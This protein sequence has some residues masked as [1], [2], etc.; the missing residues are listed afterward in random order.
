M[1]LFV[2]LFTA[3]NVMALSFAYYGPGVF[4]QAAVPTGIWGSVAELFEYLLLFLTSVVVATLGLPMFLDALHDGAGRLGWINARTL[5]CAGVFAAFV[6]SAWHTL[7]GIDPIYYDTVTMV[8]V[9]VTIGKNLEARAKRR[10]SVEL[11]A[12]LTELPDRIDVVRD[13]RQF[14]IETAALRIGDV[15]CVR[16]GQVVPVDGVIEGGCS[17]VDASG[18]TGEPHAA[19]LS[20]GDRVFAGSI[21]IDGM[22][23]V[24]AEHVASERL[25]AHVDRLLREAL[26]HRFPA[27][28][29]ADTVA[30]VLA[31]AVV[32][33][34]LAVT[35]A[36]ARRGAADDG[37][38][39]GL[40]VLLI[41]CPCALA[42]GPGL[43]MAAAIR[44]AARRGIVF[45]SPTMVEQVSRLKRMY[46][47]KTGTL[48]GATSTIEAVFVADTAHPDETIELLASIGA[49]GDHPIAGGMV[50]YA[51]ERGVR[52]R[53]VDA[54]RVLPGRGVEA[55]VDGRRFLLGGARLLESI[56]LDPPFDRGG[57]RVYLLADG[58][59]LASAIVWD[60]PRP[61]ANAALERLAELGVRVSGLS[62]DTE[63]RSRCL[64]EKLG[65]SIDG[66]L[67]PQDKVDRIRRAV[68]EPHRGTVAMVGDGINDAAA[69]AQADA[70]FA[71]ASASDLS[72]QAGGVLLLRDSLAL[73]P[74]AI[75]IARDARRRLAISIAWAAGYN[76][77]GVALALS[78]RLHPVFAATAMAVSSLLVIGFSRNAGSLPDAGEST[79]LG[80]PARE[81]SA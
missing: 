41:A 7:A 14:E 58:D 32:V 35:I 53:P 25:L 36:F 3:L 51:A 69:L 18:I 33:I 63:D 40:S 81:A 21:A 24:R 5:V 80:A 52:P 29:T 78:G 77:V 61:E 60:P 71:V 23:R 17:F 43:I 65:I 37:L 38:M 34:A 50:Q 74:D 9:V 49:H 48:T 45:A 66:N 79:A 15:V 57:P 54:Y 1:Q 4:G 20:I 26:E 46:I 55:V 6:L 10:A 44:R 19:S 62:G 13:G 22:L 16:P 2:G 27:V 59:I 30:R 31:P 11:T 76:A 72:K 42:I 12:A 39:R 68:A 64:G 73:I 47:D 56:G 67:L 8:L 75:A 70:G 28:R